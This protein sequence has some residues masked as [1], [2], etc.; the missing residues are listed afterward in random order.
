MNK[1]LSLKLSN[2]R[3]FFSEQTIHFENKIGSNVTAFYGPNGSG[4]SNTAK[5]LQ[6][7]K[8]F[9]K[10]SA[11]AE[12]TDIPSEPFSLIEINGEPIS[13]EIEFINNDHKFRYG[14]SF[15]SCE[16]IEEKL[17]DLNSQKE[18]VIF[19]RNGQK[20][21]NLST[22]K[23]FGF[24]EGLLSKTRK[25]TL[26]ITKAREDNNSYANEVFEFLDSLNV[27]TCGTSVLRS[28][29]IKLLKKDP[30]MEKKVLSFLQ[31]A[32]LWIRGIAVEDL[33]IPETIL[34]DPDIPDKIKK[35]IIENGIVTVNTMHSVRDTAGKIVGLTPFSLNS[36]ES[37]G[38]NVV[39]D[40]AALIIDTI[41]RGLVLYIDEFGIHLHS[42]ICQYILALFRKHQE[43]QL[44][45]NTHDVLL[46]DDL[47]R[48]E[49]VFIN[50]R[51]NE[52][53]VVVPFMN[54]SPRESEPFSKR[55]KQGLY[56]AKPMISGLEL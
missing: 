4:K 12:I 39:F 45:L 53:S 1:L 2:F 38:T 27:V 20:I 40:L 54:L 46:M 5:A 17:I 7:I 26:L 43:T 9:V 52:E 28:N 23:Q 6:F 3:S 10:E 31:K 11:S 37:K 16:I 47:K 48:E 25:T 50:K 36:Q 8:R 19:N 34:K 51:Q 49:I 14:F 56:G 30:T 13:F 24:T 55:Y 41:E 15:V 42:D 21:I 29:A 44:I 33:D 18:K 22:A 35:Q 32:D